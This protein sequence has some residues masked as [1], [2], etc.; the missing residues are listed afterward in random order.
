MFD[1]LE[2]AIEDLELP[3]SGEDLLE[4]IALADRLAAKVSAAVGR[5]DRAGGWELDGATSMTA[6]LR[7]RARMSG[8]V[9]ASTARTAR[10]LRHLPHT[11]RAWSEGTLSEAQVQAVMANVDDG[12]TTLFAEHEGALVPTLAQL[13]VRETALA[14]QAWR[15]RADALADHDEGAEPRLSAYLSQTLDGRWEL[16]ASLDPEG[17]QVVATAMRLAASPDAEAEVPRSPAR[18]RGD[19]LVDVCRFFLDHRRRTAHARHRPHLNVV[20]DYEDLVSRRPGRWVEGGVA[21][22]ATVQ[23]LLCDAGVHRVVTEGRSAVLDYGTTTRAVGANLWAA[24]VLR[25]RH[26]RHPGCDRS[27]PW[28]EAHHVVP[29]LDGGS[30]CLSNLVLKCSRHHH[31]GHRPGWAEKLKPD[32]TL[33]LTDPSGRTWGTQAPGV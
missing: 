28:C 10:R 31:L 26:C 29:V 14:M 15:A 23:A 24:L 16:E 19:A 21:R 17:G 20:V 4:L 22:P 7:H 8:R 25:D 13:S 11:A 5:F 12:S 9:A 27:P 3:L 1:T 32:G 30:T 18:R 6:W 2:A 33:E